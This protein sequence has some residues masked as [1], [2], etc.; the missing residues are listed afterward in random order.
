MSGKAPSAAAGKA[1][2]AAKAARVGATKK[3]VKVRTKSHF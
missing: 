2:K 1:L 3:A